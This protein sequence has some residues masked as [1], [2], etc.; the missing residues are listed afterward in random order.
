MKIVISKRN[1]DLVNAC[2]STDINCLIE[3]FNDGVSPSIVFKD[4]D[5][6]HLI[7]RITRVYMMC[8]DS[9]HFLDMLFEASVCRYSHLLD[10]ERCK[11]DTQLGKLYCQLY[12]WMLK[13]ESIDYD[14]FIV[15]EHNAIFLDTQ[16]NSLRTACKGRFD[17]GLGIIDCLIKD[18]KIYCDVSVDFEPQWIPNIIAR[19]QKIY[20][21]VVGQ[22][23]FMSVLEQSYSDRH[24]SG[25]GSCDD[26]CN[27]NSETAVNYSHLLFW[28]KKLRWLG[29]NCFVVLEEE[30]V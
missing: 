29:E 10:D 8:V 11:Q 20:L 3:H 1:N 26:R 28:A 21:D 17:S 9:E 12:F 4:S 13:L 16:D 24:K 6:P 14:T 15:G 2:R 22:K 30:N 5:V 25:G 19:I 27:G 18:W 7:R 23:H